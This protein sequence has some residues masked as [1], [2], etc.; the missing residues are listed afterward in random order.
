M[1]SLW[2]CVDC[3]QPSQGCTWASNMLCQQVCAYVQEPAS[4][5]GRQAN[6]SELRLYL[7]EAPEDKA[8]HMIERDEL[9]IFFK[10]YDPLTQKLSFLGKCF[11]K[12]TNKL[13][14]LMPYLN[15]LA[16]FPEGTPLEVGCTACVPC[17]LPS[18]TCGSASQLA[19][20]YPP[21]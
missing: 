15:K 17:K 2:C 16:K 14:D 11:A 20:L 5:F 13:P 8:L 12:K 10:L 4:G 19:H 3:R 1:V 21:I 9:L 7:E 6:Q 18:C